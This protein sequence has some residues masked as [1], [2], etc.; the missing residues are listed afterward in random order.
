MVKISFA[1][2]KEVVVHEHIIV[3][4]DDLLRSR[5]TPAGTVPLY[6]CGGVLFTFSSMPWTR[7]IVRDY[8]DGKIHWVEIQYTR[9]DKYKPVLELKDENYGQAQ[10]IRIIDTSASALHIELTKWLKAQM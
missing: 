7:D 3:P 4:L 10:K 5:I 2:I 8:L 6:W 1:P 9:L